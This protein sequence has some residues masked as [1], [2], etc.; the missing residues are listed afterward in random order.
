MKAAIRPTRGGIKRESAYLSCS[1]F[2]FVLPIF[3]LKK[4]SLAELEAENGEFVDYL[5]EAVNLPQPTLA[6]MRPP[7]S[8]D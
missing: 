8:N 2:S 5:I 7:A 1:I 6:T 4:D 3:L